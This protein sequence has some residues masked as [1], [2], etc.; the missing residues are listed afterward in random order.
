MTMAR[1]FDRVNCRFGAPMGRCDTVP[2]LDETRRTVRLFRVNL[3]SGG[4][5]DGGAYWGLPSR[6]GDRLWCARDSDGGEVFVRAV[7][8]LQA[9][10]ML[11]LDWRALRI[12]LDRPA[13]YA[14]DML[15]GRAPIPQG[16]TRED[17]ISWA[18]ASGVHI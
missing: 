18:Q 6:P 13:M 17:V 15:D 5:D 3:D 9:C 1:Q 11:D 2:A 16:K 4:Y 8:R 7:D 12:P 10:F 14:L